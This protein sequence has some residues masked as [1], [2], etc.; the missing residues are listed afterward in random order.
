MVREVIFLDLCTPCLRDSEG[1][2]RTEATWTGTVSINGEPPRQLDLCEDHRA[3]II[4]GLPEALEAYGDK[5]IQPQIQRVTITANGRH[6]CPVPGC[7]LEYESRNSLTG[8]VRKAHNTT[9][10]ILEGG[11]DA[12]WP[13]NFPGCN[14]VSKSPQGVGAH[15]RFA[16]D[17]LGKKA[18]G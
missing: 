7:G 17:I 2:T 1:A 12:E 10:A 3:Q 6:V 4:G 13:C 15:K 11:S 16:H 8:H 5:P 14:H 9:L 18:T